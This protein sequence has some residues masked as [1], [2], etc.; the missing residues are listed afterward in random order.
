VIVSREESLKRNESLPPSQAY[1][2]DVLKTLLM[3][4]E[5]PDASNRWD[6]PLF[7]VTGADWDPIC[8]Q[9]SHALLQKRPP[10]PNQS[11]QAVRSHT[12][13]TFKFAN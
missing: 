1:D 9:I 4:Y 10:P 12:Q 6:S 13:M 5:S 8:E 2:P 11:T 3:R 7:N